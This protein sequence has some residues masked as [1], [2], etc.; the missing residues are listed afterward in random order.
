MYKINGKSVATKRAENKWE[1]DLISEETG[2][3]DPEVLKMIAK[4]IAEMTQIAYL[5]KTRKHDRNVIN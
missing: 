3:K 5:K 2:N 1:Y 4:E